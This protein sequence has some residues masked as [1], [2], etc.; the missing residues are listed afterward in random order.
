[1]TIWIINQEYKILNFPKPNDKIY[2][3]NKYIQ[4]KGEIKKPTIVVGNFNPTLSN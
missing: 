3:E 1:M 4:L 2:E